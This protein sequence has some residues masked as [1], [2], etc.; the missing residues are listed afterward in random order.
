VGATL[1][2]PAFFGTA[3][4]P[5]LIL[6]TLSLAATLAVG[7]VLGWFGG[8]LLLQRLA[9]PAMP[10]PIGG[11]TP[12]TV[13]G[14]PLAGEVGVWLVP[15]VESQQT[16]LLHL[17]R[18]CAGSVPVLLVPAPGARAALTRGMAGLAGVS[19]LPDDRPPSGVLL[20]AAA[21]LRHGHAPLVLVQGLEALQPA[22]PDE[23]PDAPLAELLGLRPPELGLVVLCTPDEP[24]SQTPEL[25]LRAD[26]GALVGPGGQPRFELGEHSADPPC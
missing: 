21:G 26:G 9:K 17:A 8:R 25:H 2:L 22:D 7:G 6:L 11:A 14:L 23:P 5:D 20:D 18:R 15:E 10:T 24:L 1:A 16:L 4:Q 3:V 19:W 12:P 13:A